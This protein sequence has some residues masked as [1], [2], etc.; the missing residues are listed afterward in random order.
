MTSKSLFSTLFFLRSRSIYS[1]TYCVQMYISQIQRVIQGTLNY[2][3]PQLIPFFILPILVNSTTNHLLIVVYTRNLC[4]SLDVLSPTASNQSPRLPILPPI[5]LESYFLLK[6]P[7][8]LSEFK[9]P[10]FFIS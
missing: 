5:S 4:I 1:I 10:L 6:S 3:F 7:L 2:L 8:P 9:S